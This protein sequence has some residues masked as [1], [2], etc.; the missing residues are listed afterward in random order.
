LSLTVV[1][2]G[3]FPAAFA[4]AAASVTGRAS[5]RTKRVRERT[6]EGREGAATVAGALS[7][8]F[9]DWGAKWS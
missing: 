1:L 4:L 2:A 7:W 9:A 3:G 5:R 8:A 6:A